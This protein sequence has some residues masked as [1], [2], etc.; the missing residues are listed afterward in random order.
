M[1]V[2]SLKGA[3]CA[4]A[5]GLFLSAAPARAQV[6]IEL[7]GPS[8][9]YIATTAPVYYGGRASYWYGNH[10]YYRDGGAWRY[11]HQEPAFFRN[12]RGGY[13]GG[14]APGRQFYGRGRAGGGEFRGG[15]HMGG[16][17]HRR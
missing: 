10:W 11:Y 7:G 15:G 8:D 9:A 1:I 5:M 13:R 17:G 2:K 3:L 4:V 6:D 16:G 12:Y 14:Y